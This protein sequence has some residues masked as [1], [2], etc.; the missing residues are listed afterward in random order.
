MPD[1]IGSERGTRSNKLKNRNENNEMTGR[2]AVCVLRP[3]YSIDV[4]PAT[5]PFHNGLTAVAATLRRRAPVDCAP[6][7]CVAIESPEGN[8]LRTLRNPSIP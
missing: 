2:L 6:S 5:S 1:F 3:Y 8:V 4:A 7:N